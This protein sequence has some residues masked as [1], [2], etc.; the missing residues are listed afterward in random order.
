MTVIYLDENTFRVNARTDVLLTKHEGRV[1]IPN[2]YQAGAI[3][4]A[5]LDGSHR[6]AT[7][8]NEQQSSLNTFFYYPENQLLLKTACCTVNELP[9]SCS[10]VAM[11][12]G[13][14]KVLDK[15]GNRA[16]PLTQ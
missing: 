4:L 13:K 16:T 12:K 1:V 15:Q 7:T 9:E 14:P 10:V 11:V 5:V 8:L 2:T 3:I 6:V